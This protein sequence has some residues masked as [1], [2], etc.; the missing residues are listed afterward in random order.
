MTTP[1]RLRRRSRPRLRRGFRRGFALPLVILLL[2]I[3]SMTIVVIMQRQNAQ[4][5]LVNG[6]IDDYQTHH[7]AFGVRAI[8]RKWIFNKSGEDLAEFAAKDGVSYRFVLPNEVY[9]SAWVLD[10]QGVPVANPTDI[11]PANVR[12]YKEITDRI[13]LKTDKPL[14]VRG[15]SA[16]SIATA[17]RAILESLVEDEDVGRRMAE[18]IIKARERRPMDRDEMMRQLRRSGLE[19]NDIARIVAITTFDPALWRLNIISES[20]KDDNKRYFVMQA[21][22]VLGSLSVTSWEELI[23]T[24][25]GDPFAEK[26]TKTKRDDSETADLDNNKKPGDANDEDSS[27]N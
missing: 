7:A 16:I 18:R 9:V 15:P 23:V 1:S 5:R 4:T 19:D 11:G 10:G 12:Y 2:L 22:I 27:D 14:R 25:A 8:V 21:E 20:R 13:R 26:P 24:D 6:M 17:P 3:S